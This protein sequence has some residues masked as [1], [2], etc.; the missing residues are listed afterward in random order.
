MIN[1]V[2]PGLALWYA[3]LKILSKKISVDSNVI[4]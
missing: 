1:I 2:I 3:I 4:L